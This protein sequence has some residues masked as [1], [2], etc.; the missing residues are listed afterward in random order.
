MYSATTRH[1]R[2]QVTPRF[3]ERES[4]PDKD[5]Y[6]WAYFIEIE[7]QGEESVQLL[8]RHWNITD[9]HGRIQEVRGPGVVGEQP[10][11]DPGDSY[12][13][14][15]GVPLTTPSGIMSGSYGMVT[16]DGERFDIEVPAFS[17]DS[18]FAKDGRVLH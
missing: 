15:S 3:L 14:T 1:I 7:N 2:V 13:Y 9:A 4:Q 6:V 8:S 16:M 18:D 12:S 10:K 5:H 17:L 11:L